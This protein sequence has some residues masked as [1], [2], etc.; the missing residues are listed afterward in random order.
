MSSVKPIPE[1]YHSVTPYLAVDD[2][3]AAIGFYKKAFGATERMRFGRPG[4]KVG[5]AEIEI[6][7]SCIML[8][9][10]C[11]DTG[12]RGLKTVGGTCV[13]SSDGLRMSLIS[14]LAYDGTQSW[15]SATGLLR[16]IPRAASRSAS[17]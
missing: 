16:G 1:G 15:S 11:P 8:S 13:G 17:T 5:H 4:G 2:A 6:G 9:D 12:F 3:A 14:P 7:G 10:E